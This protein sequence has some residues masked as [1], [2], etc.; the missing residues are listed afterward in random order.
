MSETPSITTERLV[1]RLW[2]TEDRAPFAE[3]NADPEVME[4]FP[5]P[6]NRNKS[7]R[8]AD[9][10]DARLSANGHGLWAVERRDSAEFIGFVGLAPVSFLAHFTP[11]VEVGWRLARPQWGLGLATE[12]GEAAID[13]GFEIGG[14][15]E[16]VSFAVPANDRS[17][18]VMQ[19]IGMTH[20]PADDF[21]HPRFPEGHRLR[22]HLL[23]RITPDR[24]SSR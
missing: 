7:D 13:Y 14:L 23:Y 16:I 17:L 21:D 12:G 10:L 1:L 3:L 22:R 8:F 15:D 6:L 24:G 9:R 4:H 20:D 11:A 2:R 18:A 19:R 5:A